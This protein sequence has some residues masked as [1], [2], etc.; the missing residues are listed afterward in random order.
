VEYESGG[1]RLPCPIKWLDNFSMRNFTNSSV[2][3]DTLPVLDGVIEIGRHVPLPELA[4]SMEDWFQRKGYI[5]K[6]SRL[7]LAEIA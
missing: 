2:F 5:V 4:S 7:I 1:L 3:D 6:G